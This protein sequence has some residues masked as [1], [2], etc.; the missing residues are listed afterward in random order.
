MAALIS[1]PFQGNYNS[2]IGPAEEGEQYLMNVQ[3]VIPFSLND[4]WNLISRTIVPVISQDEIF[5]GAHGQ[6]GLGNTV[7]SLFFSPAKT[8]NGLTWGV[9]P[10]LY[11]PTS[12]DDLLGPEKWGIGP[13]AVAL[14]QGDGWTIG[15]LANQIW[16]VA[17]N[18]NDPDINATYPSALHFLHDQGC[19]DLH[20]EHRSHLRLGKSTSGRF[21]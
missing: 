5:P 10:V 19:M 14:W 3:P 8:V 6:L 13:T 16:S 9:G 15:A 7:Q 11:L 2:G 12:T 1:V 4:D 20:A 17:G 21:L 18:G